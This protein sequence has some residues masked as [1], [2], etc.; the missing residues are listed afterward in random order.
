MSFFDKPEDNRRWEIRCE[1]QKQVWAEF[2]DVFGCYLQSESQYN[3]LIQEEVERR[4]RI[5]FDREEQILKQIGEIVPDVLPKPDPSHST[6]ETIDEMGI[7]IEMGAT[8]ELK[9]GVEETNKVD[10]ERKADE[11]D[12]RL[13]RDLIE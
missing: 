5:Q 6:M 13:F 2:Y 3:E 4:V 8:E 10:E 1:V 7:S 9:D 12:Q 11:L